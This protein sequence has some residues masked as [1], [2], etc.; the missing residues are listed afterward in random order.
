M[1]RLHRY[2]LKELLACT[3]LA[4][5]VFFGLSLLVVL[6]RLI[7]RT[8]GTSLWVTFFASLVWG[9]LDNLENL[10]LISVLLGTVFTCARAAADNEVQA[11]TASGIHKSCL[12]TPVLLLGLLA[13]TLTAELVHTWLPGFHFTKLQLISGV[14]Q[15]FVGA[16]TASDGR[17]EMQGLT[18]VFDPARNDGNN[19]LRDV[20]LFYRQKDEDVHGHADEVWIE[21]DQA[22]EAIHLRA[23][24]LVGEQIAPDGSRRRLTMNSLDLKKS[25]TEVLGGSA[26]QDPG[27][28]DLTTGQLL[29]ELWRGDHA[30]PEGAWFVLHRRLCAALAPLLMA[31][32]AFAVG[33]L[34]R[35][36]GRMT[37]LAVSFVPIAGYY[38][39]QI[40]ARKL[41]G[42]LHQP[43]LAY[44]PVVG[45]LLATVP[46]L[47]KALR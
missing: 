39:L 30:F 34:V 14:A 43:L 6:P 31:V 46:L 42:N 33:L 25:I 45:V 8:L 44:L 35:R 36:G 20:E 32:S 27:D 40:V 5:C 47:R 15:Q 37:A 2:L 38:T 10:I 4:F 23:T 18:V 7:L 3:L 21:I 28:S 29:T 22:D 9:P 17:L 16:L 26:R 41:C 1:W 19:R 13:S 11:V 24:N 12:L